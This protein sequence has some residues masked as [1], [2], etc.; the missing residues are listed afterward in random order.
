[1]KRIA[2]FVFAL[3]ATGTL[4]AAQSRPIVRMSVTLPDG[5]TK[6]VSAPESGM[7]DLSLKDGTE[8]GV[9]PTILDS[10]PWTHVVVTVF[11]LPTA[12][13][14]VEELGSVETKTGAA[15][16]QTKTTPAFKIA[17]RSV[18]DSSTSSTS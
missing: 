10:K 6:E 11:K 18:S 4:A 15:A 2:L 12:S 3:I 16:M 14:N 1:M 9:R 13:H 7:A 5:Q 8:I 17:V